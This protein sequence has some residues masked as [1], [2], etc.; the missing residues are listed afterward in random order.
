MNCKEFG[1]LRAMVGRKTDYDKPFEIEE[2]DA[3]IK[4]LLRRSGKAIE[5]EALVAKSR[6]GTFYIKSEFGYA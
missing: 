1:V 3:R 6:E 4:V 2:L 5:T